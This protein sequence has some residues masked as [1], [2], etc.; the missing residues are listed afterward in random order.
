MIDNNSIP[1]N[2]LE[3]LDHCRSPYYEKAEDIKKI[4]PFDMQ[5]EKLQELHQMMIE[6]P[7][8]KGITG[9]IADRVRHEDTVF[10]VVDANGD[11]NILPKPDVFK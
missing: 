8:I 4:F 7:T 3:M 10:M 2:M 5:V 9:L 1:L 11:L 6:D